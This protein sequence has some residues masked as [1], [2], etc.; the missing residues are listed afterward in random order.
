MREYVLKRLLLMVPTTIGITVISFVIAYYAP[1]DPFERQL[2]DREGA[3][4]AGA[5]AKARKDVLKKFYHLD[6]NPVSAYFLWLGDFFDGERNRSILYNEPVLPL[7]ARKL[8]VTLLLNVLSLVIVYALSIPLGVHSAVSSGEPLERGVT[9]VLFVLYAMPTFWV[10][11]LLKMYVGSPEYL[12]LLPVHGFGPDASSDLPALSLVWATIPFVILP[13]VC[14]SYGGFAGLSRYMRVGMMEVIRQ[15]Y[16]RTAR[17]KGLRERVV[18]W[19]HAMRNALIPMITLVAGLLP[20][21]LGG[22]VI[23]E[24]VFGIPGMG[25]LGFEAAV[26]KDY[27]LLNTLGLV[28][29]VLVQ[30]G[31]L[32]SDLLYAWADPRISFEGG[33]RGGA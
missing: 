3:A 22:S 7:I 9:V 30:L 29:A 28:S 33:R 10:A 31:I 4:K 21:L 32:V 20:G 27:P 12:G 18:I 6:R 11:A 24:S 17:A 1:G 14:Y 26:S 2:L 5:L 23:V 8:P 13:L 19:K 25:R 16:V 15:D